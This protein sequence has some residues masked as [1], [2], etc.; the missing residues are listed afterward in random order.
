MSPFLAGALGALALVLTLGVAR[1]VFWFRRLRRWRAGG[2]L[3]LRHLFARLGVRPE[4]EPVLSA[5]AEALWREAA[6]LRE[7]G[8]AA[9]EELAGLFS[10]EALDAAAVSAALDRRLV[11]IGALRTRL[12]EALA[13]V[14]ATLDPEQR[15]RLAALVRHGGFRHRH[16]H[17]RC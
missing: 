17:G 11:R 13:R 8:R 12:A 5:E 6:G 15:A 14:H 4:Q 2:A 16:A 3:P 10:A 1:R 9:R 7:D